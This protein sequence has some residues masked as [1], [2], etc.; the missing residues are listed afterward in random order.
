MRLSDCLAAPLLAMT[1]IGFAEV[2]KLPYG[3]INK[4]L[5]AR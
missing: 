2:N 3:E 4:L 1:V 5:S